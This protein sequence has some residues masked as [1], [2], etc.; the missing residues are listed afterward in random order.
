MTLLLFWVRYLT[1]QEIHGTILQALLVMVATG[2]AVY[3][4]TKT[5]R[6]QERWA[7]ERKWTQRLVAKVKAI[8]PV[9]V[10]VV[11]GALL[12]LIS[13]GTIAGVPRDQARAPQFGA[14]NIR[15]WAPS[16]LWWLG[17]DP[18]PDL[19]EASISARPANWNVGDDQVA[20]VDGARLNNAKFRYAQ[21]YGMFLANAHLWRADFEG[22]FLSEADLRGA[23]LGQSNM[24]FAVLDQ[25]R[26]YHANLDRSNLD[27]AD[28]RRADLR[29]ANFH[30]VRW[31]TQYWWTRGSTARVST[32]RGWLAP[33]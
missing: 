2:I 21:A 26:M 11:C 33:R 30:T 22:A 6:P 1:R 31:W 3:A 9:T 19:T 10:A 32:Q 18:Y 16:I 24:R 25:A 28:L 14:A 7:V 27:G 13:A 20:S 29:E 15:R 5:G 8:N 17:Y 23:D 12:M 4:T